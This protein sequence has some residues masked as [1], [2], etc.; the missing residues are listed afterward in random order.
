MTLS[1][2]GHFTMIEARLND[3]NCK[4][5]V[6]EMGKAG[7]DRIDV[8]HITSW[9]EDHCNPDELNIILKHLKPRL[10]EYPSYEPH[11]DSGKASKKLIMGYNE[12]EKRRIT[13]YVVRACDKTPL[14]GRDIFYNPIV[15]NDDPQKANDN[16]LV[17]LFRVGSFVILSTGDCEDESIAN[18]LAADDILKS[19]VD[20]MI[21][22]HH[23]SKN[24]I[25]T[26]LL[27][28]NLKPKFAICNVDRSNRYDHP[29]AVIRQRLIS[30][31]IPYL[32]TKDGDVLV[33]TIDTHTYKVMQHRKEGWVE[34]ESNPFNAKTYYPN[35]VY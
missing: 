21:I 10:I 5:V 8:L 15:N 9:D 14:K 22:A 2:E 6:F 28:D 17:K 4:A 24:S 31:G 26:P 32:T 33:K 11:A 30:R 12:G 27:L 29:D 23:G 19:E 18:S 16:S 25:N 1:V 20:V 3:D 13:P 34:H 7:V 35:D